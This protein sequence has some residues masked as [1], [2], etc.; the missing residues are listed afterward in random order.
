MTHTDSHSQSPDN[1]GLTDRFGA[2]LSILLLRIWLGFRALQSGIEKFAGY[3]V[4]DRLVD[5][6]GAPNE[7]GLVDT[8]AE[9]FYSLGNMHGVPPAMYDRFLDEPLI[10][11]FALALYDKLLAPLL[12]ILGLTV[13]LGVAIRCSLFAMGLVY[14]SLTFG[15]ILLNQDAGVAWLGIH[16]LLITAA[17]LHIQHNRFSIMKR[18]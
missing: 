11:N 2:A 13:L 6:D 14:T 4:S 8:D 10:P 1:N 16:I 12:I 7:F 3:E 18:F 17:L 5:V 9:K 15:L